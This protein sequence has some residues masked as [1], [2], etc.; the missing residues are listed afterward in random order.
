MLAPQWFGWGMEKVV[1]VAIGEADI[2]S[3]ID[4]EDSGFGG[5]VWF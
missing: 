1:G 4:D 2:T 5:K 3:F